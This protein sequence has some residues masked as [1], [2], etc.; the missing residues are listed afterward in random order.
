VTAE[1]RFDC[2]YYRS[3]IITSQYLY[4]FLYQGVQHSK[5][6]SQSNVYS[7][8]FLNLCQHRHSSMLINTTYP[9]ISCHVSKTLLIFKPCSIEVYTTILS[10]LK[11]LTQWKTQK[12]NIGGRVMVLT[13]LHLYR[14]VRFIGGGIWSTRRKPLTC[15]KSLTN[16]IT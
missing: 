14:G 11:H 9:I 4:R 12:S 3:I 8:F 16:F 10:S 6:C 2:I 7:F 13:V 5:P 1:Y 15:C